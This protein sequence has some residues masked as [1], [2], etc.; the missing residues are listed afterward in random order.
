MDTRHWIFY[1]KSY[2]MKLFDYVIFSVYWKIEWMVWRVTR[3]AEIEKVTSNID[4]LFESVIMNKHERYYEFFP[5][6]NK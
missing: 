6:Q 2:L 1:I 3:F 5:V 4:F